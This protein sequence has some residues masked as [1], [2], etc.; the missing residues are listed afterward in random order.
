M[1][2]HDVEWNRLAKQHH[3]LMLTCQGPT[4]L[5]CWMLLLALLVFDVCASGECG[6][7]LIGVWRLLRLA[8]VVFLLLSEKEVEA[9]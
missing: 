8:R 6:C 5:D 7:G 3:R 4:L 9:F 1:P 2:P